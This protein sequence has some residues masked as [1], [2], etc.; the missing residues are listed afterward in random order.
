VDHGA[1]EQTRRKTL[2]ALLAFASIALLPPGAA[3]GEDQERILVFGDSQAQGLAGGLQRAYRDNHDYRVLDRSKISTGL[4]SRATYDWQIQAR[5]IAANER[6]NVAFAMFGAND[7]PP[8]RIEGKINPDLLRSFTEIYGARVA[9]IAQNF[10][11][12]GIPLIWVGHPIVRDADYAED[13]SILNAIY[14][15]R[16]V[17]NGASYVSMWDAFKGPDGA[18]AP[19]GDGMDG[20]P[21]RLRASDGIHMTGAGYDV[22][23]GM[24]LQV[25]QLYKNGSVIIPVP[26]TMR[27]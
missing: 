9:E 5:N 6:F 24:L 22:M 19:F 2:S 10:H 13:M 8:V 4:V 12:A 3:A 26:A 18:F 20:Q 7:R 25:V 1:C 16:A 21:T 23:A 15:S 11:Q 14:L 27:E 17:A